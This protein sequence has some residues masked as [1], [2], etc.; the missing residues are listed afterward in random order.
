ME[1]RVELFAMSQLRLL[2]L[3][4]MFSATASLF[5]AHRNR[6]YTDVINLR[7]GPQIIAVSLTRLRAVPQKNLACVKHVR[8][9]TYH[10]Q[11]DGCT[12]RFAV[13]P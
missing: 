2:A 8:V 7:H 10:D 5:T 13:S 11:A 4:G 6:L 3:Y 12:A 1:S 9:D